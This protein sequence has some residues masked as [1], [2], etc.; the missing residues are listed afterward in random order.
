MSNMEYD[1][2]TGLPKKAKGIPSNSYA[3]PLPFGSPGSDVG[4]IMPGGALTGTIP[5]QSS[6]Y[7]PSAS[8]NMP[9]LTTT[10]FTALINEQLKPL[11]DMINQ[12]Q[13]F[14]K[15]GLTAARQRAIAQFGFAP[16]FSNMDPSFLSAL[17]AAGAAPDLAGDLTPEVRA[18]AEKN[19]AEGLSTKARLE[20]ANKDALRAIKNTLASRG[21]LR[22]GETGYQLGEQNLAFKQA[23]ADAVGKLNEYLAGVAQAYADS[24]KQRQERLFQEQSS[25]TARVAQQ[26]ANVPGIQGTYVGQGPNGGAIYRGPDGQTYLVDAQGNRYV[27]NNPVIPDNAAPLPRPVETPK[28]AQFAGAPRMS[29]GLSVLYP[30]VKPGSAGAKKT[31]SSLPAWAR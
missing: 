5:G 15:A 2:A 9:G 8:F 24:E 20:K 25:A 22:S 7:G 23:N 11:Q 31:N 17:N 10:D 1:P 21:M 13:G 26:A 16:D 14:D 12:Q 27:Y 3:A 19:T 30:N 28:V 4:A 29:G 18:L 6:G